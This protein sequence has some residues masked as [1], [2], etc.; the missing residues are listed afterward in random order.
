MKRLLTIAIA[1]VSFAGTQTL[2]QSNLKG[3]TAGYM[4]STPTHVITDTVTNAGVK[5][6]KVQLTGYQTQVTV[7]A[8]FTKISGTVGGTAQLKGS[9]DGVNYVNVGSAYT[10]TDVATQT[11]VFDVGLSKYQHYNLTITGTGTMAVKVVTPWLT[12]KQP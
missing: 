9:L 2:A 8:N 11:T 3:E 6:Q 4:L 1:L 12:R 7:Q 5:V 10:L